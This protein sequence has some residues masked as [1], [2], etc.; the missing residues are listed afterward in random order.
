M[1]L[2]NPKS[3]SAWPV[4]LGLLGST[5]L[6]RNENKSFAAG[7]FS[8]ILL[9]FNKKKYPLTL[10]LSLFKH[11]KCRKEKQRMKDTCFKRKLTKCRTQR[12]IEECLPWMLRMSYSPKPL[13]SQWKHPYFFSTFLLFFVIFYCSMQVMQ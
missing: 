6:D 2:T 12:C 10:T 1:I 9:I 7:A 3:F 11:K 13:A 5:P 8:S 4:S